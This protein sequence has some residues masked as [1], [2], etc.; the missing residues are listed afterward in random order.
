MAFFGLDPNTSISAELSAA[1]DF[2]HEFN[3]TSSQPH[4][5]QQHIHN[6]VQNFDVRSVSMGDGTLKTSFA[7][8][9]NPGIPT[10]QS[11]QTLSRPFLIGSEMSAYP[12]YWRCEYQYA[13]SNFLPDEDC[14]WSGRLPELKQHFTSEHCAFREEEYWCYCQA[15]SFCTLGWDP[16]PQCLASNCYGGRWK[17]SIYGHSSIDTP[18]LTQS[19][20]SEG[21]LSFDARASSD[22]VSYDPS[23]SSR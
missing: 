9:Y 17:K 7:Q 22:Q 5:R 15:C 2:T 21:E 6:L 23:W 16:P 20:E 10:A 18:A 3:D 1:E 14:R 19:G 11:S 4:S 8:P 13:G 12:G